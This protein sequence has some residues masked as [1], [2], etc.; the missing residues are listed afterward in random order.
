[1]PDAARRRPRSVRRPIS[2]TLSRTLPWALLAAAWATC[3]LPLR[4]AE[5]GVIEP[6]RGFLTSGETF[7]GQLAGFLDGDPWQVEFRSG[8]TTRRLPADALVYWGGHTDSSRQAQVVLSDGSLLAG[9]FL[10]LDPDTLTIYSGL[11]GEVEIR[12]GQVRGMLLNAP[13]EPLERDRLLERILTAPRGADR[14]LL[15]N[16]DTIRGVLGRPR[17]AAPGQELPPG[18]AVWITMPDRPATPIPVPRIT[19]MIFNPALLEAARPQ[20]LTAEIGL[21][22]GSLLRVQP[23]RQQEGWLRLSTTSGV[24]LECDAA[25]ALEEVNWLRPRSPRVT[26]LSDRKPLGYKHIPFLERQWDY[27]TDRNVLGGRLRSGGRVWSKGLGMHS[28]S[29]LAYALEEPAERFEAEVALDAH[30]G[31]R[32]SVI[33]RVFLLRDGGWQVAEETPVVRGGDSPRPLSVDVT[34]A[35]GLALIVDFADWGDQLDHANWLNARLV[36]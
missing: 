14:L 18:E 5:E 17:D 8:E 15:D 22:D 3:G 33:F 35:R 9:D 19:A 13:V 2:W 31:R 7:R 20:G 32:G 6:P 23:P 24:K 11:F 25:S 26:Y 4:G 36:Q 21:R 30:S 16:G 28:T 34:G 10:M 27:G 29:R 12:L 1:M